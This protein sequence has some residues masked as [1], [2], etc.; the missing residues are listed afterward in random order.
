V[1]HDGFSLAAADAVL[2]GDTLASVAHLVDQSLVTVRD[3]GASA[4][5]GMLETVR[6]FGRMRL[7]GSG[8]EPEASAAQRDWARTYAKGAGIVLASPDQIASLDLL[9]AEEGNLAD[10]LRRSLAAPDHETAVILL[11]ALVGYWSVRGEH[12]R[13]LA[14]ADAVDRAF[15]GWSAPIELADS[16]RSAMAGFATTLMFLGG[17]T[18]H[19]AWRLLRELGPT[20]D[21]PTIGAMTTVI[22]ACDPRS[23]DSP[24]RV[25]ELCDDPQPGIASHALMVRAHDLENAGDPAAA[26]AAI[27]RAVA[28]VPGDVGPWLPAILRGRLAELCAQLGRHRSAAEHARRALPSLER[29]DALDDMVDM[30]SLL[31]L[32]ALVDGHTDAAQAELD[33]IERAVDRRATPPML[34]VGLPT[35]A[36]ELALA[37]GDYA[38][39]LRAYRDAVTS[40]KR[41][42]FAR[43][44][45]PRGT[46]PW[47]LYIG[48]AALAAH[49]LYGEPGGAL[50]AGAE[51]V[52]S[53]AGP[54]TTVLASSG[55]DPSD[56]R[57][58]DQAGGVDGIDFPIV[59]SVLAAIALWRCARAK[60]AK[61]GGAADAGSETDDTIRLA[62][63]ADRFG[64]NRR[65]P[66]LAW[67]RLEH[68]VNEVAPGRLETIAAAMTAEHDDTR[69]AALLPTA[70]AV[71]QSVLATQL[72]SPADPT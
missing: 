40:I 16:T 24:A 13:V 45:E 27:E 15:A 30:R 34:A 56:D 50:D 5:Y 26:V 65:V 8:E 36:A 69:A 1:F 25:S 48:A 7:S 11:A 20:S 57:G 6:E 22:L 41:M 47:T 23:D 18:D 67:D 31:V 35:L 49:A 72:S 51:L 61:R 62:V 33:A 44:G 66:S 37:R 60:P 68:A 29:L 19:A 59:G 42:T 14:L 32:A 17:N 10:V 54:I 55:V 71:V 70:R 12:D 63:I 53:L 21:D 43:A 64:Y 28:L 46:E 9:R 39:G 4:R 58:H 2:G 3:T 52:C 38:A